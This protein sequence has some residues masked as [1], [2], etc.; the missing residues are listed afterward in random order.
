MLHLRGMT[1]PAGHH[2]FPSH[3][4]HPIRNQICGYPGHPEHLLPVPCISRIPIN[5]NSSYQSS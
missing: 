2:H 5:H 3:L 4:P 1:G